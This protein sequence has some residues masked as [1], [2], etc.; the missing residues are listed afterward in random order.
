MDPSG[1]G[2]SAEERLR[3]ARKGRSLYQKCCKSGEGSCAEG[4]AFHHIDRG[5]P[6]V[7]QDLLVTLD[8]HARALREDDPDGRLALTEALASRIRARLADDPS[9]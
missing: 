3:L 9:T 8:A 4:F 2:I 6:V 5:A 7:A 1:T